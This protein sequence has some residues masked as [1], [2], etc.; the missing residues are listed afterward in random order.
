MSK[1]LL[2]LLRLSVI[3]V[4]SVPGEKGEIKSEGERFR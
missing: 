1:G 3:E 4:K 2:L